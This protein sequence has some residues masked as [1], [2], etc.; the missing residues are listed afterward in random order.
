MKLRDCEGCLVY[1]TDNKPLSRARVESDK[2]ETIRLYFSNYKL[3]S[4]RFRTFVDFYDMQQGLIRCYCELVIRKNVYENRV[5][6]PW[7]ADCEVLEI[8]DVFQR[9]KDLR[10][11]VHISTEFTLTSG[12]FFIGTIKNISAGGIFLVT[13][14]AIK[15]GERFSFTHRFDER[16]LSQVEGKILRVKR[17]NS[18]GFGY[19]CQFVNLSSETEATIRKYVFAKQMEKQKNPGRKI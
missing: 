13:S 3:R 11:R 9:Q 8:N 6:E 7:M 2:N 15:V 17:A 5:N 14:Q 10:V 1:G 16:E 4:V 18:G 19:G 12:Q